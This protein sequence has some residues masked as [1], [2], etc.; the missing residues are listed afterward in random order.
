MEILDFGCFVW[1]MMCGLIYIFDVES[2][3]VVLFIKYGNDFFYLVGLGVMGL[4]G[5]LVK[6]YIMYGFLVVFEFISVYFMFLNYWILV[7]FNEIVQEKGENFVNFEW[8]VYVDGFYFDKYLIKDWG[9]K[10]VV[11]K[12]FFVGFFILILDDW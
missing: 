12:E 11:V 7:V 3:I 6:Y 1:V 4:Y 9:L 10:F 8:F 2:L 5:F